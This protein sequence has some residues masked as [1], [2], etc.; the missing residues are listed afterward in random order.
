MRKLFYTLSF[1]AILSIV[2]GMVKYSNLRDF[3]YLFVMLVGFGAVIT[4]LSIAIRE[5][6]K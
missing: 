4:G 6:S 1:L 3:M 2:F 5:D